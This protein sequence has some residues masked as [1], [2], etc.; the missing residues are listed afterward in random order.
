MTLSRFIHISANDPVSFLFMPEAYPTVHLH[1]TFFYTLLGMGV[2]AASCP[3]DC[4]SEWCCS[5]YWGACV[6]GNDG[7]LSGVGPGRDLLDHMTILCLV[8]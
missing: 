4:T 1:R 8:F 7:F 3:G 5:E 6:F 2:W